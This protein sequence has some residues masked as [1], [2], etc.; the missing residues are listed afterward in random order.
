MPFDGEETWR[1]FEMLKDWGVRERHLKFELIKGNC[2]N[3]D[4]AFPQNG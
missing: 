1:V 3:M 4:R 2:P